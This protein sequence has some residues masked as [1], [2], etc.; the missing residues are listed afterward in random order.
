MVNF[1]GSI[2][3]LLDFQYF[4]SYIQFMYIL[5]MSCLDFQLDILLNILNENLPSFISYYKTVFQHLSSF[6]LSKTLLQSVCDLN[7]L[8]IKIYILHQQSDLNYS[9]IL[10]FVYIYIYIVKIMRF[11]SLCPAFLAITSFLFYLP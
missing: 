11:I 7:T 9:D 8:N 3:M 2:L 4:L 10:I 1:L 6:S 5:T